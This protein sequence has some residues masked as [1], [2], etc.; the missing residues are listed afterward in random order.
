MWDRG[1][2]RGAYRALRDAPCFP[3]P[4]L[5]GC[6]GADRDFDGT[7]YRSDWP[8][9]T[10]MNA[11]SIAISSVAGGGLGPLSISDDSGD[12]DQPFPIVHFQTIVAGSEPPCQPNGVGC[13]V[14]PVRAQFYPF[15]ALKGNRDHDGR[16]DKC[17]LLFGNFSGD[18]IDNFG[19]DA[20]YGA[21]NLVHDFGQNTSGPVSNPCIGRVGEN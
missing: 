5:A 6:I 18:D 3:G 10:R 21:P 9:G 17:T 11:T 15:F 16:R 19:G 1:F 12:Y 4:T 8:D 2:R 7:S 14:P 20:Q 13:V